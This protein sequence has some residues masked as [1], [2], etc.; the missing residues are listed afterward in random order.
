MGVWDVNTPLRK[1]H[2]FCSNKW[3]EIFVFLNFSKSKKIPG[4]PLTRALTAAATV[5]PPC[6]TVLGKELFPCVSIFYIRKVS[7]TNRQKK[8]MRPFTYWSGFSQ[9]RKYLCLGKADLS[10]DRVSAEP[11][12]VSAAC[13]P[14]A[15][16]THELLTAHCCRQP[17][18]NAWTALF[19]P[20]EGLGKA[21][22]IKSMPH[23]FNTSLFLLLNLL[24]TLF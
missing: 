7:Y 21:R 11:V 17:S 4:N 20:N 16:N 5:S 19:W 10:H 8:K 13:T 1:I 3:I 14:L 15:A 9:F 6:P 22:K 24:F 18:H 23:S 2:T 12:L